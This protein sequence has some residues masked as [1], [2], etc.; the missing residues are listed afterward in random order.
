MNSILMSILT[1]VHGETD[2]ILLAIQF[3]ALFCNFFSLSLSLS[4]CDHNWDYSLVLKSFL[5]RLICFESFLDKLSLLKYCMYFAW[6]SM[7]FV[8]DPCKR[9]AKCKELVT[10]I[11]GFVTHTSLILN[12]KCTNPNIYVNIFNLTASYSY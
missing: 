3:G 11:W 7:S 9:Y 2:C 4:F 6:V 12:E 10:G 1:H 5:N 8:Y